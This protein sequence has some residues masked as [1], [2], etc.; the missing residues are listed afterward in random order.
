MESSTKQ[1]SINAPKPWTCAFTRS[2]T[3]WSTDKLTLVGRRV[4]QTWVITSPSITHQHITSEYTN[5]TYTSLP[6]SC[7]Y[8]TSRYP[9]CKGVLIYAP[10]LSSSP[11]KGTDTY[12]SPTP[13]Q[14]PVHPTRATS[15]SVNHQVTQ[16][17]D[18]G[19]I[20]I[21][22]VVGYLL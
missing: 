4:T 6:I 9:Y 14:T 20:Q 8:T 5:T 11:G 1:S 18:T 2:R 17:Q 19:Q 10:A 22:N 16:T 15:V 12:P 3:E 7:L 13:L 21:V